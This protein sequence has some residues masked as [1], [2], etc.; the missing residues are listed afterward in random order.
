GPE[1][2]A[3]VDLHHHRLVRLQV[4]DLDARAQ[5]Q[6]AMGGG[7]FVVVEDLAA[8]GLVALLAGA[9]E[10]GDAGVEDLA[11]AVVGAVVARGHGRMGGG[12]SGEIRARGRTRGRGRGRGG[13]NGGEH[14]GSDRYEEESRLRSSVS[15][16]RCSFSAATRRALPPSWRRAG[17]T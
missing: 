2:A 8:G 11:H 15:A 9:V 17:T 12:G 7:H 4:G 16:R 1:G 14:A 10:A 13:A 6:E 5:G 3:V